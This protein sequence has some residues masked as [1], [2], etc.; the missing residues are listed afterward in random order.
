VPIVVV[1]AQRKEIR[2]TSD[3]SGAFRAEGVSS[4][5]AEISVV[6]DAFLVL[7]EPLDVKSRQ[8]NQIDLILRSKP[9]TANARVTPNE[10]TIRQQVQFALDSAVIL[11]ESF[12]LLTE[13]ADI[14]IRHPE[15]KRVEVQGHTDNS[16]TPEHNQSLSEGRAEA[17]RSWL[18]EHGVQPDRLIARGYGQDRPLAPNV[19]AANRAANRRVQF[20]IVDKDGTTPPP[21]QVPPKKNVLP[22]F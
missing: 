9:K 12:G 1:D 3:P 7:A 2:V 18:V 6:A 20:I 11:P 22:G 19:T 13:I 10:I 14:L 15:I 5:T 21:A 17:V 8:D 16:G 4:G